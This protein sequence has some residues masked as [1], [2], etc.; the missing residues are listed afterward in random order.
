VEESGTLHNKNNEKSI[1][2]NPQIEQSDKQDC[3]IEDG[4]FHDNLSTNSMAFIDNIPGDFNSVNKTI[5]IPTIPSVVLDND[6]T[7]DKHVTK[8]RPIEPTADQNCVQQLVL[9]DIKNMPSQLTYLD[10]NPFLRYNVP[11]DGNC[12]FHLLSLLINGNTTNSSFYRNIICTQ[13]IHNWQI[14]EEMVFHSYT[15]NMTVELH[16]QHMININGW[17]TATEIEAAANLFGL[18]INI[19]LQQT[20]H[21]TLCSFNASSPICID[22]LLSRN[23]FSPLKRVPPNTYNSFDILKNQLKRQGQ[24]NKTSNNKK[25]ENCQPKLDLKRK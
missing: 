25:K 9:A 23:H 7:N 11:G 18:N 24:Q 13:I 22:I 15:N 8:T 5:K 1:I 6:R 19:W 21:W 16:Q 12:F 20:S 10:N 2:P 14:W 4:V 3:V 17:A